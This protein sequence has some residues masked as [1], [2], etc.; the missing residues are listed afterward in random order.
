VRRRVR[1]RCRDCQVDTLDLLDLGEGIETE[2]YMVHR[3]VWAEAGMTTAGG[4]LCLGCLSSRLGR[5]L[6][7][8]DLTGAPCNEPSWCDSPCMYAL[9]VAAEVARFRQADRRVW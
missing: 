7:G 6:T 2:Y 3:D 1:A 9:K 8:D 5:P 4:F